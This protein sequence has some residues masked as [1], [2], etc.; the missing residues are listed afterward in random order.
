MAGKG[1]RLLPIGEIAS[2]R[3]LPRL[4]IEDVIALNLLE[5]MC[6][7]RLLDRAS[8]RPAGALAAQALLRGI[9]SVA[10]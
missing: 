6:A 10:R 5:V 3:Q 9:R 2:I 7:S 1:Y 4:D 8:R